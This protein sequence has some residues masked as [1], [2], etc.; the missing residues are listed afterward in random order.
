MNRT[1]RQSCLLSTLLAVVP[2]CLPAEKT[3]QPVPLQTAPN[4]ATSLYEEA[5]RWS[6]S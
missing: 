5:A 1:N 4:Q 2:A 3:H 6:G